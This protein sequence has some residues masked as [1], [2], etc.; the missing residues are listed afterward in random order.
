MLGVSAR[1]ASPLGWTRIPF[2]D[3]SSFPNRRSHCRLSVPTKL[4]LCT[5]GISRRSNAKR[6]ASTARSTSSDRTA[7]RS[8][9]RRRTRP[10]ITA[11]TTSGATISW[12]R[13]ITYSTATKSSTSSARARSVR[14]CSA[15][16]TRRETW[17]RSRSSGTRSGSITKLLSRSRFSRTSFAG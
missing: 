2:A 8:L 6:S 14:F 11:T 9:R 12:S 13:T 7:R 3:F 10:A 5:L 1:S 15:A 4:G 17:S 16:I